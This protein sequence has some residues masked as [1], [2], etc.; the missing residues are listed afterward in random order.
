MIWKL[1]HRIGLHKDE[2]TRIYVNDRAPKL[3]DDMIDFTTEIK[4]ESHDP[5]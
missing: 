2:V 1:L 5:L 4:G 3:R